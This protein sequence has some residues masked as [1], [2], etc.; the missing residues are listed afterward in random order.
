[1][2]G[3]RKQQQQPFILQGYIQ[4]IKRHSKAIYDVTKVF[5]FK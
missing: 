2:W 5:Y 1:M 3:I 4:L